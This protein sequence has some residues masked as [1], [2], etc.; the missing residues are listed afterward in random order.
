MSLDRIVNQFFTIKEG[1]ILDFK[2]ACLNWK[3]LFMEKNKQKQ[4]N[5]RLV[6]CQKCLYKPS[7]VEVLLVV[8]FLVIKSSSLK[9]DEHQMSL[10]FGNI[11]G[12]T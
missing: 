11:A 6:F 2:K 8:L 5:A 3:A 10:F 1:T 9:T 12:W 4:F 7:T